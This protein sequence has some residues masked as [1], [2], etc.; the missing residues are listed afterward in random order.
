[1]TRSPGSHLSAD[2]ID[3]CLIGVPAPEIQRH[4]DQ[5]SQCLEQVKMDREIADQVAALPLISPAAG[6]ADRVMARVVVPDPFAMRSL[7]ATRRRLFST[8]KSFATAAG[9]ALL[10]LGSMVGSVVW[11]LGHQETLAALGSWLF[12]Q[13]GQAVWLG[14]QGLASNLLEQ[15]WYDGLKSL[16]DNPGRL[17]LFS[18]LGSFAYLSGLIALRHLLAAPTQQVAHAGL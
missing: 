6:F 7:Q 8:P 14:V 3:A 11:S 10:L 16:A 18:A 15:P 12:A 13:G 17:A 2:E 1:M 4:L 5:C 9:F